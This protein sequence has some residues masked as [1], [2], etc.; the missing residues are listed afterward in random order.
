M[1]LLSGERRKSVFA[2]NWCWVCRKN[3]IMNQLLKI[4]P[5]LIMLLRKKIFVSDYLINGL[6]LWVLVERVIG[7]YCVIILAAHL[8]AVC[9]VTMTHFYY[10]TKLNFIFR[11]NSSR[12][13]KCNSRYRREHFLFSHLPLWLPIQYI[14]S[15]NYFLT[16][17]SSCQLHRKSG[18]TWWRGKE[19]R[20]W[21][22]SRRNWRCHWSGR[23]K[24][25]T[26]RGCFGLSRAIRK[27]SQHGLLHSEGASDSQ[28][29]GREAEGW[30][31][32]RTDSASK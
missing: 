1:N 5:L 24:W 9:A 22:G 25:S 30:R 31:R 29:R 18:Y 13:N 12:C 21:S 8:L 2:L 10:C 7:C 19:R 3:L 14:V 6:L 27:L 23:P 11:F 20:W 26:W 15:I 17:Y 28:G 16:S 32:A 4:F